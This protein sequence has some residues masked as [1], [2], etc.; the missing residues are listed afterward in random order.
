MRRVALLAATL[1]L[2]GCSTV[3][4]TAAPPAELTDFDRGARLTE[5]WRATTGDAFNRKWVRMTPVRDGEVLYSANV[6]GQV[7]AF[8]AADGDR[9]WRTDVE[10]WLS[11]GV[12]VGGGAV[13]VGSAEGTVIALDAA[14]GSVRWRRDVAGELLAP[15]AAGPESIVYVRTVDGRVLALEADSGE[16]RWAHEGDVPALSLRGNSQPL[17]V[18][19]GVLVGQDNG[20]VVALRGET[21]EPLWESQVAPPE[22]ETEIERMVDIDGRL[23]LGRDVLYAVTYQGRIAEIEPDQG[24]IGWSRELS[25]YAGLTVDAQ[26]IYVTDASSHVRA[27]DPDSGSTLWRQ[28][29]LAHRRL[30]AAVPVPGTG[31]LALADYDGYVHLLTRADG[32]I[33]ARMRTGG[34]GIMAAPEPLAEGR[35]AVQTQG[36]HLLVLEAEALTSD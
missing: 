31:L 6:A 14:D 20:M 7:T 3:E 13:Y 1:A 16:V 34:F 36:A 10:A 17:P 12:G 15:P 24:N 23:G 32:R 21:G 18:S 2:V 28:E 29:A 26:R 25:S 11:A 19:G 9:R 22:G 5:V 8:D 35:F 27:L 4:D 30:T 33:V